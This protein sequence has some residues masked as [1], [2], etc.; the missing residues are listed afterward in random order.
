[1]VVRRSDVTLLSALK[2]CPELAFVAGITRIILTMDTSLMVSYDNVEVK[3][4]V[5]PTSQQL[6]CPWINGG[7]HPCLIKYLEEQ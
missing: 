3:V 1:M 2:A 4:L 6:E 7:L 5:T